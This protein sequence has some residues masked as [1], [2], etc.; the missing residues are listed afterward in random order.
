MRNPGFTPG[1][2]AFSG[3]FQI[4]KPTGLS[5]PLLDQ[6][7]AEVGAGHLFRLFQVEDGE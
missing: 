4:V 3:Y 1:F 5:T 7:Y 2:F 6:G